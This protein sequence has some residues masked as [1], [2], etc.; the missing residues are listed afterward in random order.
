MQVLELPDPSP[1]QLLEF[2]TQEMLE[3]RDSRVS[4]HRP[5]QVLFT[6]RS[7]ARAAATSLAAL[8]IPTGELHEPPGLPGYVTVFSKQLVKAG[9]AADGSA[10]DRP[11][12][13]IPQQF[14]WQPRQ[15][16]AVW[17]R[18]ARM[19]SGGSA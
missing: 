19:V 18:V 12:V 6:D 1:E 7:H 17:L 5:S 8:G 16:T 13:C 15:Y 3:P 4:Q 11:G 9:Q 10:P 14:S 2:I